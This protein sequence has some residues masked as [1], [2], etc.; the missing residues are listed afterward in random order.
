MR[1]LAAQVL[2]DYI[3]SEIEPVLLDKLASVH[4]PHFG[5]EG[6][7]RFAK[8]CASAWCAKSADGESR[9]H[10]IL[11]RLDEFL[12]RREQINIEGF[13]RFRL[14]TTGELLQLLN[15]SADDFIIEK[16]YQEFINLLGYF[17]DIQPRFPRCISFV[18]I[19]I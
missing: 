8:R 4:H 16:E 2:A 10:C 19:I 13:I 14:R 18:K 6:G 11:K 17:V 1:R 5:K 12:K 3:V 7:N 15:E 9:R